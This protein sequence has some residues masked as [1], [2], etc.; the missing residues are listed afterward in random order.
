MQAK[1]V[2]NAMDAR[3][4]AT[5][6]WSSRLMMDRTSESLRCRSTSLS[7]KL[8]EG[9]LTIPLQIAWKLCAGTIDCPLGTREPGCAVNVAGYLLLCCYL[10]VV[11]LAVCVLTTA[12]EDMC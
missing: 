4:L 3:A 11:E 5:S 10:H 8:V 6:Y 1:L 9:A 12:F 7:K 2:W